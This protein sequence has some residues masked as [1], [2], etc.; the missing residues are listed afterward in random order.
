MRQGQFSPPVIS[1]ALIAIFSGC[2][3]SARPE[4]PGARKVAEEQIIQL[5]KEWTEA[6]PKGD[7]GLFERI[8]SD[9]YVI[10]DVDGSIRTKQAEIANFR[11]EKQTGQTMD[12]VKVRVYGDMAVVVGRFTIAGTYAGESN[13]F[14]ARFTDV[15][16]KRDGRWRVAS[17]Q[18]TM[19][20]EVAADGTHSQSSTAE[21]A[22]N[23]AMGTQESD[24]LVINRERQIWEALKHKDKAGASQLLADDLTTMGPDGR[25][26][27]AQ[28]L[29]QFDDQ[30]TVDDYKMSDIKVLRPSAT[31]VLLL[32]D[33]TCKGAGAVSATGRSSSSL[34]PTRW[35]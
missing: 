23:S 15:W 32:Y 19:L 2:S 7:I 16:F 10:V 18:N 5:E 3:E 26:S 33:S 14:A 28:W 9:D 31:T 8:A 29:E 30:Y 12:D 13:N 27:R 34:L 6:G 1:V 25:F 20:P 22:S 21:E 4:D 35:M 17:S 24:A 11:K